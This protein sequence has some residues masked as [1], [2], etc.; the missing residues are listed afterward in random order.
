MKRRKLSNKKLALIIAI[1]Y[2]AIATILSILSSKNQINDGLLNYIFFPAT[3]FPT[4]ILFTESKPML[5]IFLCQTVTIILVWLLF[6][7]IINLFRVRNE[8][9]DVTNNK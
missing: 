2:V 1:I 3:I 4:L 8:I 5:M 9:R 6:W 7:G